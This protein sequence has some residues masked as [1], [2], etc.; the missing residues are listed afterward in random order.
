[1]TDYQLENGTHVQHDFSKREGVVVEQ[2]EGI[3]WVKVWFNGDYTD[4]MCHLH[5]LKK[6]EEEKKITTFEKSDHVR[7]KETGRVGFVTEVQSDKCIAVRFDGDLDD[8]ACLAVNLINLGKKKEKIVS[9]NKGDVVQ[10]VGISGEGEVARDSGESRTLVK[11]ESGSESYVLTSNL[12]L[13]RGAPKLQDVITVLEAE[14]R[15]LMSERETVNSKLLDI[16]GAIKLI[17]R[18]K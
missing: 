1:M 14:R 4:T 7:H 10:I 9:F 17:N 16:E 8:R 13:V 15:R 2:C 3:N 11:W 12:R 18:V 6:I 5:S